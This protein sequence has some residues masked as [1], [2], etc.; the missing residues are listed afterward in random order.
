MVPTSRLY[1]IG[2]HRCWRCTLPARD[3]RILLYSSVGAFLHMSTRKCAILFRA[4]IAPP[5]TGGNRRGRQAGGKVIGPSEGMAATAAQ[6]VL[7]YLERHTD[8]G[9]LEPLSL[10]QSVP[11]TP[12]GWWL[13]GVRSCS[14]HMGA[15]AEKLSTRVDGA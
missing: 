9:T 11:Y 8:A 12:E 4:R 2:T 13:Q 10:G 3:E 15:S 5:A 7:I 6:I 14:V 1:L